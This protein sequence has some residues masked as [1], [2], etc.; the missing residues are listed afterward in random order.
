M[1]DK[2]TVITGGELCILVCQEYRTATLEGKNCDGLDCEVC[3]LTKQAEISFKAGQ[4]VER[5]ELNYCEKHKLYYCDCCPDCFR[6]KGIREVV[7][8]IEEHRCVPLELDV[9]VLKEEW[10]AFKKEKGIEKEGK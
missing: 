2:D 7:E 8:W 1:G 3:Q 4:E 6:E 10:Q 9:M 5:R